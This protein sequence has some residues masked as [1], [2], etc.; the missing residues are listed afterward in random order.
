MP[1]QVQVFFSRDVSIEAHAD[2]GLE[3]FL[4]YF[5]IVWLN[6][7]IVWPSLSLEVTFKVRK[8]G[9]TSNYVVEESKSSES[10]HYSPKHTFI[11]FLTF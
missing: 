1:I 7:D 9:K 10:C 11:L 8:V 2:S 3:N 5:N 6:N 4:G